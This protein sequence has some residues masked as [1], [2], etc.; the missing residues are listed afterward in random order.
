VYVA[1]TVAIFAVAPF[2]PAL[3]L[4]GALLLA[5]LLLC[6]FFW[7]PVAYELADDRLTVFFRASRKSFG[8][9][10]RCSPIDKPLPWWAGIRLWGNGGLFAGSG[11]FWSKRYGVFRAYVTRSK[12]TEWILVETK[13]RKIIISPED[14]QA[15]LL[16]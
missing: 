12:H 6:Y 7:A 1:L 16:A 3:F 10:I 4:A 14:P 11:I 15:W 2:V 5:I 13:H 8:P 9:V